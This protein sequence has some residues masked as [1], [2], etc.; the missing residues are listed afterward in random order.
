MATA[1][2]RCKTCSRTLV[3]LS[4]SQY[5]ICPV[6]ETVSLF[7]R[8]LKGRLLSRFEKIANVVSSQSQP[9]QTSSPRFSHFPH[10]KISQQNQITPMAQTRKKAVLCGVT[11]NGHRKK[12]EASVHNVNSMQQLLVNKLGFSNY[13]IF[14]LTGALPFPL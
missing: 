7:N 10:I 2:N 9:S 4:S 14:I 11:Y 13:S 3:K 1:A 12:L 6:C 5:E 8:K